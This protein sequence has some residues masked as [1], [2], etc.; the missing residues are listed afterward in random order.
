LDSE[1]TPLILSISS[2][3][4]NV[5]ANM[6]R[7]NFHELCAGAALLLKA[8]VP[9]WRTL[10]RALTPELPVSIAMGDLK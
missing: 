2:M 6:I 8:V 1:I 5:A 4:S 10:D 3:D 7:G 9:R